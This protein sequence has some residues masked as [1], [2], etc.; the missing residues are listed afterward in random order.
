LLLAGGVVIT[1]LLFTPF[2]LWSARWQDPTLKGKPLIT[3]EKNRVTALTREAKRLGIV[4]GMSQLAAS[5]MARDVINV[6]T[7]KATLE[8]QWQDILGQLYGYTNR[9][10]SPDVGV[11]FADLNAKDTAILAR[12][13]GVRCG[14]GETQEASRL[15]ALS[16][17]VA[18]ARTGVLKHTSLKIFLELGVEQ[19]VLQRLEWLGIKTIGQLK[20]WKRTQLHDSLGEGSKPLVRY[21]FGPFRRDVSVYSPPLRLHASHAFDEPACE[22]YQ[23]EPV[24]SMLSRKLELALQRK[25]AGRLTLT[26]LASR[27][28]FSETRVSRHPLGRASLIELHAV[29]LLRQSPATPLGIDTLELTLDNIYAFNEQP[30]LFGDKKQL[31]AAVD[32]LSEHQQTLYQFHHVDPHN[33]L[34]EFAWKLVPLS[35]ESLGSPLRLKKTRA[36][37]QTVTL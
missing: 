5:S 19:R 15:A 34:P 23:L 13:F 17:S 2:A 33:P 30:S 4:R 3:V 32:Y 20:K 35:A 25:V 7:S 8:T 6:E 14:T 18:E 10:E 11:V 24:I 26:A 28:E 9:L 37:K 29:Q 31:C 1:C 36:S 21:L 16:G 27:L 12:Q 22:P